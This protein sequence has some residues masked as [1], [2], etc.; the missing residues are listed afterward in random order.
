[1]LING[2]IGFSNL[3]SC[4]LQRISGKQV[5]F[6]VAEPHS[7]EGQSGARALTGSATQQLSFYAE[8]RRKWGDFDC[9]THFS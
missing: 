9:R 7:L 1:M 5:G 2:L 8:K 6:L 3:V 4:L